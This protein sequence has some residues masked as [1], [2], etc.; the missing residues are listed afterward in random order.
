VGYLDIFNNHLK[1]FITIKTCLSIS[2]PAS[3]TIKA[4][5]LSGPVISMLMPPTARSMLARVLHLTMVEST[6]SKWVLVK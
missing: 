6:R 2:Y 4:P 1:T 5:E 3:T